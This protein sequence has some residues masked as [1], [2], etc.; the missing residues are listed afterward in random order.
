MV[1]NVYGLIYNLCNV[2]NELELD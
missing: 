2:N 1:T